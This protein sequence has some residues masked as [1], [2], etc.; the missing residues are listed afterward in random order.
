[1][2]STVCYCIAK[3]KKVL[4]PT[5]WSVIGIH[6]LGSCLD[7]L[8]AEYSRSSVLTKT[9][10]AQTQA[11]A[12]HTTEI[13]ISTRIS[14]QSQPQAYVK[15]TTEMKMFM[16]ISTQSQ[17]QAYA[18]HTTEMKI[19]TRISTQCQL[20]AYFKHTT[21]HLWEFRLKVKAIIFLPIFTSFSVKGQLNYL[22][23]VCLIGCI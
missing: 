4:I 19:L 5:R 12:K 1:M 18:K 13:K 6:Y 20:Q 17:P 23:D 14:T 2:C 21:H 16:R 3:I 15:H 10:S 8:H 11:Y 22:Q 7:L 9:N